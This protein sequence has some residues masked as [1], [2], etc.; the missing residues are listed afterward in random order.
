M[1]CVED[2]DEA[3]KEDGKTA[4]ESID[5]YDLEVYRTRWDNSLMALQPQLLWL[6]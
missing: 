2:N 5:N 1:V 6:W 3:E 4:M